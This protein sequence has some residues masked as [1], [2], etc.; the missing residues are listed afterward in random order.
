MPGDAGKVL[1][2]PRQRERPGREVDEEQ[3]GTEDVHQVVQAVGICDAI[4]RRIKC[5]SKH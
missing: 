4:Y 3:P 2:E 5:E 1:G